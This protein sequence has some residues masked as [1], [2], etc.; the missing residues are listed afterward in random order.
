MK[1]MRLF[2][3]LFTLAAAM[4]VIVDASLQSQRAFITVNIALNVF[5]VLGMRAPGATNSG[6]AI[7]AR[8]I[9]NKDEDPRNYANAESL[10]FS[11]GQFVGGQVVAQAVKQGAVE[12]RASISPNPQG[13]LLYASCTGIPVGCPGVTENVTAGTQSTIACAYDVVV[14]TTQTAWTVEHGLVTDFENT[15][16][17][18][19]F[20]G[21]LLYNNSHIGAPLPVYTPFIVYSD[22]QSWIVMGASGGMKTFCVDLQITVPNSVLT[23]VY[24]SNAYYSLYY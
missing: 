6:S 4:P 2:L 13:T 3:V 12:V 9:V 16:N 7:A 15:L 11:D 20:S 5:N 14:D 17:Q 10:S 24:N 22:G 19:A 1:R 21:H 23:G 8:L 18:V